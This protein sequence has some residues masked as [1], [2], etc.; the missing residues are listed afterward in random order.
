MTPRKLY[1]IK[2][3]NFNPFQKEEREDEKIPLLIFREKGPH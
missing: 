3:K 2:R 1:L